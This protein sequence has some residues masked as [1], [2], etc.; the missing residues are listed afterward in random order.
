MKKYIL[1]AVI[2]SFIVSVCLLLIFAMI[3]YLGNVEDKITGVMV[4][5]TYFI[6]NLIGGI[7][8]GKKAIKNKY[9]W[10]I[11]EGIIYFMCIFIFSLI[12]SKNGVDVN[13][14]MIIAI[15][16][17]IFGGMIGGMIS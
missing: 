1:G 2:R 6:S 7:Y 13:F 11:L 12:S 4:I 15:I 9:V 14:S 8:I 10:G 17:S 16:I 5:I 3:M